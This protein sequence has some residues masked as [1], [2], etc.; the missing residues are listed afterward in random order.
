MLTD[1]QCAFY[2]TFGYLHLRAFL[3][4]EIGWISAEYDQAWAARPDLVHTGEKTTDYP[5]LFIASRPA[6]AGLAAHPR[7]TAALDALLG[8]GWSIYGGDGSLKTGDTG[9]HSDCV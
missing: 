3:A 4:D 6:L 1:A 7:L 9:W 8:S 2:H 5:G